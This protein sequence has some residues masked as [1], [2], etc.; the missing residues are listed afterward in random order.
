MVAA[1]VG[2]GVGVIDQ[3]AEEYIHLLLDLGFC[4]QA[5]VGSDLF[6]GPVPDGFV[7]IEVWAVSR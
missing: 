2:E 3:P 1:A 5:F 6:P 7:G 4:S